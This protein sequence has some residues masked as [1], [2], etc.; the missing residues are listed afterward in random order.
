MT[1]STHSL[2]LKRLGINT[3]KESIVYIH[4]NCHI[5]RSEG[6]EA[7]TRIKITLGECSIIATLNTVDSDLLS[8]EEASLSNYAWSRLAAKEGDQIY[9]SHPKPLE[10]LKYIHS[11]IYGNELDKKAL[12]SVIND[13]VGGRL[14][15]IHIATFLTAIGG[16]RLNKKEI[17]KLT[18]AMI[19]SGCSLKW[20]TV[21]I[22]DKHCIGGLPGNRTSMIIVPIVSAFGLTIPKT[23]SRAIISPAGTADT[24]EV[25]CPVDLDI[26]AMK[27][28]VEQ[29]NGCII[30]GGS[31]SLSPA[32]DILI[33]VEHAID[34]DGEG[35][36]VA[37]VLSKKIA[38]GSTH[39]II[40][41]PVGPTAKVRSMQ[42]ANL[43]KNYLETIGQKLGIK[44]QVIFTNGLQPVGR[45]M[46]PALEAKDVLKVLQGDKDAPTLLRDRA[47]MLAG[48]ILE[49]SQE[50]ACGTGRQIAQTILDSGKAWQ[51]FQAICKAQGGMF[52][53]PSAAYTQEVIARK[54]GN[55]T[56]I[57]NRRLAYIAKLAGA[58]KSKAAGVEL[59]TPLNSSVQKGQPLFIVHSETPGELNYTIT[60]LKQQP[61]IIQLEDI[62]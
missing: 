2:Y 11:K 33:R 57:D 37:S 62:K 3:Y 4:K 6:F 1:H 49:F 18:Q 58:P 8:L 53:I 35:Q 17:T 50:V 5:C 31:V 15:D 7:Q 46:G 29:E 61:D 55:V 14:S 22:V 39:V 48:Y 45:G 43:L 44:V 32:D 13:V 27:K 30:W 26:P 28:V 36:L 59:L 9:L 52:E 51:K 42:M 40:D 10:S 60:F 20:S 21:P 19:Q 56:M 16:N 23:S 38:A 12:T 34:L 41:M 24:M 25:L 54:S 47:L